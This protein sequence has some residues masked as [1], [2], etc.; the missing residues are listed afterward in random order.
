MTRMH[1]DNQFRGRLLPTP[2][3]FFLPKSSLI[4]DSKTYLVRR[5]E[6]ISRPNLAEGSY[7]NLPCEKRK[8]I[9]KLH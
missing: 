3:F 9:N 5:H 8:I 7:E 1:Q 2:T 4:T 6:A